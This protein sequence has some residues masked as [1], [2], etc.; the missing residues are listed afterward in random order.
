MAAHALLPSPHRVGASDLAGLWAALAAVAGLAH[1]LAAFFGRRCLALQSPPSVLAGFGVFFGALLL[2]ALLLLGSLSH[3]WQPDDEF[4]ART[5]CLA[6]LNA[7][8]GLLLDAR[9]EG[10]LRVLAGAAFLAQVADRVND[11]ELGIFLCPADPEAPA[12][13]RRAALHCSFRGP[14]LETARRFV[15]GTLLPGTVIAAEARGRSNGEPPHSSD[16][17]VLRASGKVEMLPSAEA[18]PHLGTLVR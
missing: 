13:N 4:R 1:L 15:E 8:G 10:A 17:C 7:L 2:A 18:A 3:P 9:E 12:E 16:W 11:E 6:R 5:G 14:D